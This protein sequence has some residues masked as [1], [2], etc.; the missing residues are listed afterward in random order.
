MNEIR[1]AVIGIGNMGSAHAR[2]LAEGRVPGL[3]L[4]RVC[5]VRPERLQWAAETL[6]GVETCRDWRAL[7]A[8]EAEVD[9]VIIAVPTCSMGRWRRP[10][11][12]PASTF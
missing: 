2:C 6:P 3:R 4:T 12:G 10:P 11:W 5:D 1:T 8:P 7:L 9:A